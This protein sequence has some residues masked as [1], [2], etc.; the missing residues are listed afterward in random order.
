M[1]TEGLETVIL[2]LGG[3]LIVPETGIDA[4]FLKDFEVFIRK[5][6][7]ANKRF[8]IVCGGGRTARNYRDAAAAVIG[9]KV[10]DEDLDW[11]GIHTTRLNAHM[12]RTIFRDIAHP[13]IID[14]YDRKLN[15]SERVVIAAGWKPGWS[16]DYCAT[17]LA[18]MYG[19]KTVI[20][21]S[22]IDMV[23]TKD[24]RKFKDA[25]P[26]E[27]TSWEYFQSLVGNKWNPGMNVPFDPIAT[28]N[29]AET[30]LTIVVLKGNNIPN[31]ENLFKGKRFKGTVISPFKLDA[32]FFDRE[33]YEGGILY[34]GHG[35]TTSWIGRIRST[36]ANFYRA[37]RVKF[38][39]HPR[40]LLD[41]GCATGKMIKYLR[42]FGVDAHGIELSDYALSKAL[43]E[44]KP[45]LK[46]GNILEIPAQNNSYDVVTSMNVL[47]HVSKDNIL[48]AL[49]ETNR[50]A[51]KY[52]IHKVFTQENWWIHKTRGQDISCVSVFPEEWWQN[53]FREN[54]YK[55]IDRFYPRLPKFMETVF[56]LEKKR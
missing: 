6:L 11:L 28:K 34:K 39:L 56:V 35:Y 19:I 14:R 30:G 13:R 3:A 20:N 41:V 40:S 48:K 44:V 12:M 54:G 51:K 23:F 55:I 45:Y 49:E 4:K 8:F 29:A 33:Y 17:L 10:T 32:S 1:G 9:G 38:L 24:P 47:E 7:T 50:V 25:K 27:K 16:T 31:L 15:I 22:N 46:K 52:T 5:Q 37:F 2:S 36:L 53:F 43:N 18:N 21:M 26:I 42:S